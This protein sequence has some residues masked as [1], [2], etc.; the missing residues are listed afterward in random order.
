MPVARRRGPVAG[1]DAVEEP[2]QLPGLR[3]GRVGGGLGDADAGSGLPAR[4]GDSE[5]AARRLAGAGGVSDQRDGAAVA[6]GVGRAGPRG[7]RPGDRLLPGRAAHRAGGD[8]L[9]RAPRPGRRD[10][11]QALSPR[12]R[13][14][15]P[16]PQT[17]QAQHRARPPAAGPAAAAGDLPRLGPRAPAR[18]RDGASDRC[19]GADHRG[20]RASRRQPHGQAAPPVPAGPAPRRLEPRCL[21][22]QPRGHSVRGAAGCVDLLGRRLPQRH[23]GLRDERLHEGPPGGDAGVRDR[24]GADRLRPR[25]GGRPGRGEGRRAAGG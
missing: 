8:G 2:L 20:V 12:L 25:R 21:A 15:H 17:A 10:R 23:R 19:R 22:H 9:P 18:L 14:P 4:G 16:R 11:D 13:R 7:A 3:G 5:G 1:G 6:S 24:A